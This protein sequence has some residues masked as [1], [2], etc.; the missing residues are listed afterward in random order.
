MR[1]TTFFSAP[2]APA[3]TSSSLVGVLAQNGSAWRLVSGISGGVPVSFTVPAITPVPAAGAAAAAAAGALGDGAE[4]PGAAAG[5][6]GAGLSGALFW[7]A[8][9]KAPASSASTVAVPRRTF[10]VV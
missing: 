9:V 10:V 3:I 7:Q 8:A 1:T 6:G 4:G 2:P 5:A